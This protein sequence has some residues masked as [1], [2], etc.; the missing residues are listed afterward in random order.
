MASCT[1]AAS[2][3]AAWRPD[4]LWQLGDVNRSGNS[5]CTDVSTLSTPS[6]IPKPPLEKLQALLRDSHGEHR[7]WRSAGLAVAVDSPATR[8]ATVRLTLV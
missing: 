6:R 7:A 5:F 3:R 8:V 1:A 4:A 2:L